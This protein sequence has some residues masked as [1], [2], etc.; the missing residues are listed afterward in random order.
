AEIAPAPIERVCVVGGGTMGA[1]IAWALLSA[2]LDV[3]LVETDDEAVARARANLDKIVAQG[4]KGGHVSKG[5]A[6][7]RRAR[8]DATTEFGRAQG[9]GLAIEAVFEDI[10]AKRAVFARLEAALGAEA[11]FATN[12]SYLDPDAIAAGLADPSRLV[13]LHFFAPAHVMRLVEI[14]RAKETSPRALAAAYALAKRLGKVPVLAGACEGFVGNRIYARYREAAETILL[15]GSTPWEI[16][17]AMTGFGFAMGPYETQDLSGLD[18]AFANR[19][20]KD[21]ARDP[22]RRYPFVVADRMVAEGRLGR[23]AGVGWYRYPGGG[24]R[25]DDPLVE[26]MIAEE[27]RFAKVSRRAF[28]ADEIVERCTLAMIDEAARILEEG[29]ARSA[30]EIDLVTALG[31]GF[32]RARGGLMFHADALGPARVLTRL[33]ALAAEDAAFWRPAKLIAELA[34][35]GRTFASV[36]G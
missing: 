3:T 30:A 1:G 18:I 16:D 12:T 29:M 5:Q 10:G 34:A 31:Y 32:P 22:A 24:P 6:D 9:A 7:E 27:A 17:S 4:L 35:S 23:K 26:D 25:V 36:G 15:D 33:E 28:A 13:G 20:R 14:V 11:I 2:G 21:A 19:R 8:L